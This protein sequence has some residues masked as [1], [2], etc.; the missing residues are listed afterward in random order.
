MS[1]EVELFICNS[2]EEAFCMT[3]RCGENGYH[4]WKML[5]RGC[6]WVRMVYVWREKHLLRHNIK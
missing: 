5:G 3:E 2:D 6:G 1:E 4:K